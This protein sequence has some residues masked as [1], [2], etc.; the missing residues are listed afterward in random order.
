MKHK[1]LGSAA[2]HPASH[3]RLWITAGLALLA[4]LLSKWAVWRWLENTPGQTRHLIDGFLAIKLVHN[5][6]I[7]FGIKTRNKI[8]GNASLFRIFGCDEII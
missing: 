4:D 6:G 8:S 7:A 3:L 1:L 5:E 2:G